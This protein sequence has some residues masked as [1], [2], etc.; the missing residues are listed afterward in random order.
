MLDFE[1]RNKKKLLNEQRFIWYINLRQATSC[2][3]IKANVL[4]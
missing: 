2:Y 3:K 4:T 1:K